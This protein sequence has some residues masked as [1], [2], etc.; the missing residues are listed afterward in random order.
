M[1]EFLIRARVKS[2]VNPEF[3]F[4]NTLT[5]DYKKFIR[6][7]SQRSGQPGVNAQEYSSFCILFPGFSEQSK[8][9]LFFQKIDKLLTLQKKELE[10]LKNIK[11]AM[12]KKMFV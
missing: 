6:L 5:K 2:D 1:L 3:V 12:L 10:K 4:Q 9:G 8:I 7:T 11:K